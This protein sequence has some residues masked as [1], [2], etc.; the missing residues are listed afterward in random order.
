MINE[1]AFRA[2]LFG[3]VP[4]IQQHVQGDVEVVMLMA[5]HPEVFHGGDV[6][7]LVEAAEDLE[8]SKNETNVA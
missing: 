6:P 4:H 3:L 2:F 7:N 8:N 1:E 5:Q